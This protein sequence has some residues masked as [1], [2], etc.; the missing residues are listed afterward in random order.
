MV[1]S[2]FFIV[3]FSSEENKRIVFLL[4]SSLNLK[5]NRHERAL[6]LP[7]ID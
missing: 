5:V 4:K 7:A 3:V 6:D 1:V 2:G